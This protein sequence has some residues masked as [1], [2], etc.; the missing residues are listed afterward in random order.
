MKQ[1]A[2]YKLVAFILGISILALAGPKLII[3]AN[4]Q[5]EN[6]SGKMEMANTSNATAPTG[7]IPSMS[8]PGEKTFYIF[9]SEV[10]NVDEN[11]L[12]V[13]G[14]SYSV[15]TLIA[16]K[17][18][19][20]TVKFYNVDDVKTE[21]HS[22][23]IGDPYKVDIDLGFGQNGNATFTADQT[24]LFTYYCRYHLPVMTGQLLVLP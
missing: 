5:N 4:A 19:K 21:R 22:F 23:T 6:E 10:E 17:G 11:K 15:H 16:N 14:D 1:V 9:T 24:G 7:K 13:A 20:V 18:D 3:Q 12:K 8:T 2:T